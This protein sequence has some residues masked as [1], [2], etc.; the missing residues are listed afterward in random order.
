MV[1]DNG[2]LVKVYALAYFAGIRP[3]IDG[4]MGKLSLREAELIDLKTGRINMPAEVAKNK[5]KRSV[6]I[7]ENLRA[8]LEAYA[9][10]PIMPVNFSDKNTKARKPLFFNRMKQDTPLSLI[11]S[12]FINPSDAQ[13]Y[14]LG[15]RRK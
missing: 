1:F 14:K 9:D 7:S 5:K 10:K 3:D 6:V 11:M 4:E 13:L 8:W 15:T 12:L 2:S